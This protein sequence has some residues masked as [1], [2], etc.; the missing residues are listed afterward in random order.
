MKYSNNSI[1]ESLVKSLAAYS[2]SGSLDGEPT[3]QG[4]WASGI[5]ALREELAELEIDLGEATLVDGSGLSL[6]NRISPRMLVRA[7]R[8]GSGFVSHRT[9]VRRVVADRRTGRD[10]R[11]APSSGE[12]RIRAKTGLLSDAVGDL[13]LG[14][15][16]AR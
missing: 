16:G 13:A 15:R 7:L 8:G 12:G 1:A 11:E 2:G 9:G 6:Q 5:R 4:N 14:I 3:H 10:P